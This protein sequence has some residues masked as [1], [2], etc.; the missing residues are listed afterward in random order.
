MRKNKSKSIKKVKYLLKKINY[1]P[2]LVK[3]SAFL[4]IL[5]KTTYLSLK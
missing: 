1:G 2:F 3:N 5:Y 4:L